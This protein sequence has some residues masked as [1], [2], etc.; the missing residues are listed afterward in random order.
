VTD[1]RRRQELQ[2]SCQDRRGHRQAESH[3]APNRRAG[4]HSHLWRQLLRDPYQ[5]R[6]QP[7]GTD[8]AGDEFP[9]LSPQRERHCY[10]W[11]GG[12]TPPKTQEE[13][14]LF[15]SRWMLGP[16]SSGNS[17]TSPRHDGPACRSKYHDPGT[18]AAHVA[19]VFGRGPALRS[20]VRWVPF[21]R[22]PQP[23]AAPRRLHRLRSEQRDSVAR[24][25]GH[26]T[27]RRCDSSSWQRSR[28]CSRDRHGAT[29]F[30]VP[31][32]LFRTGFFITSRH[33]AF[34]WSA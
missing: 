5:G 19:T 14:D 10:H 6:H 33:R 23:P 22:S 2:R 24:S 31:G 9:G 18:S 34:H 12:T 17:G 8:H 21:R 1:S 16:R 25:V 20:V 28:T 11:M 26:V 29:S 15:L 30:A 32:R 7:S 13:L 3:V 27:R 4:V